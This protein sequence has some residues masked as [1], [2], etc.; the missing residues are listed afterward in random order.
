VKDLQK[1]KQQRVEELELVR[2]SLSSTIAALQG[3]ME[4]ER[5]KRDRQFEFTEEGLRRCTQD[6]SENVERCRK[7]LERWVGKMIG[8]LTDTLKEHQAFQ[9]DLK[10]HSDNMTKDMSN[11]L[12][13]MG[14]LT[15]SQARADII[16]MEQK[17]AEQVKAVEN[18]L[19]KLQHNVQAESEQR[20]FEHRKLLTLIED[21][22][23][24]REEESDDMVK[25][26]DRSLQKIRESFERHH[27]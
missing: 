25:L 22:K 4:Q 19:W 14:T 15:K 12:H 10:R 20:L 21:E 11:K 26:I 13:E 1:D 23:R 24:V 18:Q 9:E 17:V 5:V 8:P 6:A 3:T 27:S 7:E 16:Q 2:K